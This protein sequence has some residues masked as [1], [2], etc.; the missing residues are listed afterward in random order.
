MA[1]T[2]KCHY[3][4]GERPLPAV[5]SSL[6]TTETDAINRGYTELNRAWKIVNT[7]TITVV[8]TESGQFPE[9]GEHV[10]ITCPEVGLVNQVL[11]TAGVEYQGTNTGTKVRLTLERYEHFEVT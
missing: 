7:Y 3:G 8:I 1:I 4:S 2:V 9:V 5:V 6:I 10:K 11:Y